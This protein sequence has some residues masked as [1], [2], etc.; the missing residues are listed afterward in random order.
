MGCGC[1][2]SNPGVPPPKGIVFGADGLT[3]VEYIGEETLIKPVVG[4][5]TKAIYPFDRKQ[6]LYVDV[7]DLVFLLGDLFREI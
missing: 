6:K 2:G 3:I 1:N 4:G 7:R 5:I